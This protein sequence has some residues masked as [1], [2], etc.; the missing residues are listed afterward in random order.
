MARVWGKT[1]ESPVGFGPLLP[2]ITVS[3]GA[4]TSEL[5]GPHDK[6]GHFFSLVHVARVLLTARGCNIKIILC[7]LKFVTVELRE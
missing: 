5:R 6:L 3:V 2:R 1:S 4:V 7:S